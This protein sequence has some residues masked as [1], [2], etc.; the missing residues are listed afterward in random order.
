MLS[1]ILQKLKN[2]NI[3]K[4]KSN[5]KPTQQKTLTDGWTK[6]SL[7]TLFKIDS[8]TEAYENISNNDEWKHTVLVTWLEN[9][10]PYTA[11]ELLKLTHSERKSKSDIES[12]IEHKRLMTVS[13]IFY[14]FAIP[15]KLYLLDDKTLEYLLQYTYLNEIVY[16]K[17]DFLETNIKNNEV[18]VKD[19]DY[20]VDRLFTNPFFKNMINRFAD[21]NG[22]YKCL[23]NIYVLYEQIMKN[24]PSEDDFTKLDIYE[25]K[26]IVSCL[27]LSCGIAM[28]RNYVY[29]DQEIIDWLNSE[30][31]YS[32]EADNV[33]SLRKKVK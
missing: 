6:V 25:F 13:S 3:F 23:P 32:K 7:S 1:S 15:S 16:V 2:I 28:P 14:D 31:S 21:N 30:G 4:I 5:K 20:Y 12:I 11:I 9:I 22:G 33:I 8:I 17:K 29:V 19:I 27:F 10:K 24:F 18:F 26:K